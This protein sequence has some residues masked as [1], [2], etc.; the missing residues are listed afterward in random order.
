VQGAQ[1]EY[2]FDTIGNRTSA[3]SRTTA[4]PSASYTAN[5]LNQYS[6]RDV[7]GVVDI[8]GEAATGAT[9]VVRLNTNNAVATSRYGEYFWNELAAD[10]SSAIFSTTNLGVTA[11]MAQGTQSL[12]RTEKHTAILPKTPEQFA[13]D[14]DGNLVSDGLW[15]NTWNGENRLIAMES[16]SGVPAAFKKRLEFKYDYQGRR[17]QK[18]V[19]Q[20][21]GYTYTP[22]QTNT[23]FWDGWLQIAEIARYSSGGSTTNFYTWAQDL[24]GTLQGA[25]G[26]GGLVIV[27][28]NGT[29]CFPAFDG[30]GNG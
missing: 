21:N 27:S 9:V 23:F 4:S 15:T 11:Y 22:V 12:V 1:Y 17:T 18:V 30:N 5:S 16:G 28:I 10:N 29:N 24:S 20:W 8:T 26:V 13:Y 2:N 7:L 14:L 6:Q 3:K 25:G 19:S